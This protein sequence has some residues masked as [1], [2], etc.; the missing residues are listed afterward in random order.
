MK[1]IYELLKKH[2]A[3]GETN[4]YFGAKNIPYSPVL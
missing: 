1:I 3:S 2:W 4:Y